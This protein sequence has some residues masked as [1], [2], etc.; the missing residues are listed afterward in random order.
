MPHYRL[1]VVL[2]WIAGLAVPQPANAQPTSTCEGSGL[3]L[4]VRNV[5]LSVGDSERT[6]GVRL[7]Y[8]DR[9][10]EAAHGLNLTLWRPHEAEEA[11]EGFAGGT[12]NGIA[13]GLPL[14]GARHLRG[15]GLGAGIE[16]DETLSGVAVAPIGLGSGGRLRGV[17]VGGLGVGAGDRLDG[18]MVGGLGAGAGE[19]ANGFLVGGLGAG[20]GGSS[21]GLVLGGLGAG[22]GEDANCVLV[23]GIGAGAGERATGLLVGG[24]GAGAGEQARGI[25]LGGLGAGAGESA[26]GFLVGGLGA[27]AGEHLR[28]IGMSVGAVGAGETM[29]GI[30]I[31]G[32]GVGAG[33]GM[34][35]IVVSG[36]V[37][38]SKNVTGL[39]I[40]GGYMRIEE[41]SLRGVS[42][43]GFNDIR[44]TQR[45][46][47]IGLINYARTLHGVQLGLVNIARNNPPGA[48][49]LPGLNLNL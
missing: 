24:A 47:T 26:T 21:T 5:G 43:S 16:V 34:N 14:T 9:C 41:G 6:T 27:G 1:V 11:N 23:G 45:G 25:L 38:G 12:V 22:A 10:L 15:I 30:G 19:A 13:L 42:V 35:G 17:A 33:Q 8:R 3:N 46:L 49:I 48:T 36:G 2:L 29:N 40:A 44:G 31:G 37:A 18:I 20:A 28:G 39:G 7:N 32:L 4:T